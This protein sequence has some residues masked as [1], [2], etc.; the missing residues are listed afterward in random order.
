MSVVALAQ[1]LVSRRNWGAAAGVVRSGTQGAP[2]RALGALRT[3]ALQNPIF[4]AALFIGAGLRVCALL[5]YR[6]ALLFYGD[7]YGY[8]SDAHHLVPGAI[9]PLGYSVALALIAPLHVLLLVPLLQHL[10]A[11]GVAVALYVFLRRRGAS[12]LL[13]TLA[14]APLLLDAYQIDVEQ[15]VLAETLVDVLLVGGLLCLAWSDRPSTF[16]SGAAGLLIA[17]AGLTRI[18][19]LVA[20]V[21]AVLFLLARRA[22]ARA[23]VSFTLA[24]A[25]PL[26]AYAT[27]FYA[28]NGEFA[29]ETF[30]GRLLY[31]QVAPYANCN[32]AGIPQSESVLCQTSPPSQRPGSTY[33]VWNATSPANQLSGNVQSELGAFAERII[34]N[35]PLDFLSRAA[36]ELGHYFSPGRW[37][38]PRDWPIGSWQFLAGS[39]PPALHVSVASEGFSGSVKPATSPALDRF[40]RGYQRFAFTP[41]PLLA[42]CALIA[43]SVVF[44]KVRARARRRLR[45]D[46]QLFLWTA[47]LI[48]GVSAASSLFDYRYLLPVLPLL[49]VAGVLALHFWAPRATGA[50]R[51]SSR[52]LAGRGRWHA[53][54]G[55]VFLGSVAS[56]LVSS[57]MV[58]A[59]AAVAPLPSGQGATELLSGTSRLE[60]TASSTDVLGFP[61]TFGSESLRQ[62]LVGVRVSMRFLG[63]RPTISE[64]SDFWM[65]DAAGQVKH[66]KQVAGISELPTVVLSRR[67][68]SVSGMV[69]FVIHPGSETL[70]YSNVMGAGSAA[71]TLEADWPVSP[72]A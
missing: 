27:V 2:R 44:V 12:G 19:A 52:W 31:G 55:A 14:T 26:L 65:V 20:L 54:V 15:F 66:P 4:S 50:F 8:L 39:H 24:F 32:G 72:G 29:L 6:P 25:L 34:L 45:S 11:L 51:M 40:L 18:V 41:G 60:M 42:A 7:S 3:W 36:S 53:A 1:G 16:C 70:Y 64:P 57:G 23:L 49:P 33:Y 5:A 38:G 69:W 17:S 67:G 58:P 37:I 48:L 47:L 46:T 63:G 28:V 21:P 22:G 43:L 9:N 56:N 68:Q 13:A 59:A 61:Q 71:W 30:S 62:P 35:Q 10:G